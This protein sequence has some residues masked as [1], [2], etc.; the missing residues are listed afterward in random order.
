[1]KAAF[2]PKIN[3][4]RNN[5]AKINTPEIPTNSECTPLESKTK[6]EYKKYEQFLD[7]S[8]YINDKN[9]PQNDSCNAILLSDERQREAE[10]QKD[11]TLYKPNKIGLTNR[12]NEN[13]CFLNALVQILYRNKTLREEFTKR[14]NHAHPETLN[15]ENC[16]LCRFLEIFN[17]MDISKCPISPNPIRKALAENFSKVDAFKLN[18][19]NCANE[20]FMELNILIR[21]QIYT[22]DT[23]CENTK[24]AI[25]DK[26]DTLIIEKKSIGDLSSKITVICNKCDSCKD[27]H[28]AVPG[29]SYGGYQS[30]KPWTHSGNQGQ[31]TDT[32]YS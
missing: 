26:Q 32:K 19:R 31:G 27:R 11:V 4:I 6:T 1:M 10:L 9:T 13:N 16:V 14:E 5:R 22:K 28:V 20:L 2:T 21:S 15:K 18:Q 24:T 8:H 30:E 29:G 12:Y 17:K 7:S 25:E 3:N 23:Y